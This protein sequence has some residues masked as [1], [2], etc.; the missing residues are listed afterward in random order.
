MNIAVFA[1]KTTFHE[2]Y[3]GLE[4]QNKILCEGL[5]SRGYEVTIFSPKWELTLDEANENNLKYVFVDCVYRMGPVF[6]FFGSWQRSN[7]LNR[8][9]DVFRQNHEKRKFDLVLAQSSA[10]LGVIKLKSQLNIKVISIAHGSIIGEY[11]T[12]LSGISLPGDLVS[13]AKNTGFA[14]KN[15]FKRQREFV[16][17]SD[18]LVAVSNFV[19]KSLVEET[20]IEEDKIQVI[21]NGADPRLFFPVDKKIKR[22]NKLLYVGQLI[23]SKGVKELLVMLS[24][25]DCLGLNL[26]LVGSGELLGE[27]KNKVE[28][29]PNLKDRVILP[30]KVDYGELIE[31]YYKNSDYGL[32]VLPT[33]RFEGFPMVLA[34]AMFSALPIVAYDMGGIAD[35][36]KT[37]KNGFLINPDDEEQFKNRILEL[38][39]N[40]ELRQQMSQNSLSVAY[41]SFTLGGMLDEYEK[42]IQEVIK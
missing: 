42:V 40:E 13:L 34:E 19:K 36:V 20:F 33:K 38:V 24:N 32:L 6:G 14:L 37:G 23:G 10:G 31:K 17:G 21:N 7:W 30:G 39:Q 26:A 4:I 15:F 2:G 3:G 35:A 18:K 22:G 12:F 25:P 16:H 28:H 1:K 27:L 8:S 5:V 9:A 11:K 41:E 29:D